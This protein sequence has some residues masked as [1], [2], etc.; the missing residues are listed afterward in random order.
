MIAIMIMIILIL[1]LGCLFSAIS[2]AKAMADYNSFLLRIEAHRQAE[3]SMTEIIDRAYAPFRD[4]SV[5]CAK[6]G[7]FVGMSSAVPVVINK[8]DIAYAFYHKRCLTH[9]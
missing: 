4:P 1:A 9:E 3:Q 6:C 2:R 8:K 7:K 5:N